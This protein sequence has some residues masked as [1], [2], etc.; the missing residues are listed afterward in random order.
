VTLKFQCMLKVG[1]S[2]VQSRVFHASEG[3]IQLRIGTTWLNGPDGEPLE[4]S[5]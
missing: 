1:L 5:A 4:P 2:A 3:G